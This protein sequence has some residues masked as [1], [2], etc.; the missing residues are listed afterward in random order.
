MAWEARFDGLLAAARAGSEWAWVEIY[1]ELSP[2]VLGYLRARG[3]REPKDLTGEVFLQI[4]RDLAGFQGAERAFRSWVFVIA[5]N[6]LLDERRK[7]A[8]RPVQLVPDHFLEAHTILDEDDGL[9]EL[10]SQPLHRLISRLSP[11]QQAVLLLRILGDLTVDEVALVVGKRPGA[12]KALQRRA[13][14]AVRRQ[15]AQEGVTL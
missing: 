1:D 7:A 8:R 10:A 15:L 9:D 3:A 4:V 11:D 13:L 5:H 6:R 2:R 14:S 12:V